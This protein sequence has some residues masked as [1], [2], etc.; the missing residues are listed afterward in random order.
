MSDW[1]DVAAVEDFPP[2]ACRVLYI[3]DA[4]IAVVNVAGQCHAIEDVCSHDGAALI[5]GDA[6]A[7]ATFIEGEEIT[8]PRHGARFCLKTGAALSP[9]AYEPIPTFP[10]RIEGGM[11]QVR[12]DRW[13]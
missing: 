13:D 2:G 11:V 5:G 3:D 9:P 4:A 10:I 8:C 12:D 6:D 7:P 1:V